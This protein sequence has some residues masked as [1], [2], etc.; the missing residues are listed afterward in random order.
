[1]PEVDFSSGLMSSHSPNPLP[2]GQVKDRAQVRAQAQMP[3][4]ER[5]LQECVL[6]IIKDTTRLIRTLQHVTWYST[7]IVGYLPAPGTP[8]GKCYK[9]ADFK[10]AWSESKISAERASFPDASNLV[11]QQ[12]LQKAY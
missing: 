2:C 11:I 5:V 9:L 1:M 8:S 12:S 10:P 7:L 4:S 6:Y 3:S